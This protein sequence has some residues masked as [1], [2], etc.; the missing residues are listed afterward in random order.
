MHI[1]T[2]TLT[3]TLVIILSSQSELE[4]VP[5]LV[6][7]AFTITTQLSFFSKLSESIAYNPFKHTSLPGP[8]QIISSVFPPTFL[9]QLKFLLKPLKLYSVS[10]FLDILPYLSIRISYTFAIPVCLW[11]TETC[12][13]YF[14][15]FLM[16]SGSTWTIFLLEL[17]IYF[18]KYCNNISTTSYL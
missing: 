16:S 5:I 6:P 13:L 14:Y 7:F 8:S 2:Y 9:H 4:F 3:H 18:L 17:P 11:Q 12:P 15:C 10:A 1:Q